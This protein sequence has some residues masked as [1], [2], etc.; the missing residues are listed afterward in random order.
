MNI[1]RFWAKAEETLTIGRQS[2]HFVAWKGSDQSLEDAQ[3][4]AW[5]ALQDR[6]VRKQRG[7]KLG[8]Y[9]KDGAPLREEVIQ[10]VLNAREERIAVI[11]RNAAGCLVLNTA[12]VMFIDLDFMNQWGQVPSLRSLL[13]GLR[14]WFARPKPPKLPS[15]F[16]QEGLLYKVQEWHSRHSDWAIRVYRTRAGFRL[17][18]AHALFDPASPQVEQIMRELGADL[19]YIRLCRSQACF[20][21]RL[22]PKPW[23]LKGGKMQRP[24]VRYPWAGPAEEQ[25]QRQWERTY[26]SRI[27]G[28][29][30]CKLLANLGSSPVHPEA[31][32][33]LLLHDQYTLASGQYTLASGQYTLG[34]DRPLA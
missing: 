15:P 24:P 7:E 26:E 10:E 25:A 12:N 2:Y 5:Q 1:P 9:P 28:F 8:Q 34:P 21:A 4:L 30:V 6:I 27:G 13:E 19:R 23:R 18:V 16:T 22:T 20:R 14:A 29:A 17:L 31:E 33:V 3:G 11:T 32:Q